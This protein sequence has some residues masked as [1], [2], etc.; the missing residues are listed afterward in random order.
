VHA[1]ASTAGGPISGATA[2]GVIPPLI[3]A[4][5]AV[6]VLLLLELTMT[7]DDEEEAPVAARHSG[8]Y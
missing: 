2:M 7:F 3:I 5:S 6:T 1:P 8:R 4:I